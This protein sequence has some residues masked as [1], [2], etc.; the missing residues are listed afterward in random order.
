MPTPRDP[1]RPVGVPQEIF[2]EDY[3][4]LPK[5][6]D[7][8]DIEGTLHKLYAGLNE[9]KK[10]AS[11]V[12]LDGIEKKLGRLQKIGGLI[13]LVFSAGV[14]YAIF[15]DETAT[16]IEVNEA[17]DRYSIEHNGGVNPD[18]VDP[19]THEL[20]G[21]HPE[22]REAV[23]ENTKSLEQISNEVLPRIESTQRKMDK[24]T[25]YQFTFTRWQADVLEAQRQKR[26][27]PAKPQRLEDIERELMLGN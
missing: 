26:K 5:V 10:L 19:E 18:M 9:V 13:A 24:R 17:I 25:E 27:P 14:G 16:D 15:I 4:P 20:V 12:G 8:L 7:R 3:T 11:D 1:H 6:G 21:H 23:E 22:L 2:V